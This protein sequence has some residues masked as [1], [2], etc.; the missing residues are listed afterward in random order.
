MV[1]EP[2]QL[3]DVIVQHGEQ[4]PLSCSK[5]SISSLEMVIRSSQA[6]LRALG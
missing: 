1:E 4:S 2:L 3:V 6:V 5:K